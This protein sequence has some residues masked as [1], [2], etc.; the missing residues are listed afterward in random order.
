MELKKDLQ[1]DKGGEKSTDGID[2]ML[3][4]AFRCKLIQR[5]CVVT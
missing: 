5:G 3:E 2:K 4:L 1:S